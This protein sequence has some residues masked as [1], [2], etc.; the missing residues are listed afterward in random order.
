MRQ[1]P[2]PAPGCQRNISITSKYGV[3]AHHNDLFVA[4]TYYLQQAQ[5]Q[6]GQSTRK[7]GRPGERVSPGGLILPPGY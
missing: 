6:A 4:I 3:C 5:K 1:L 7:G 2:C